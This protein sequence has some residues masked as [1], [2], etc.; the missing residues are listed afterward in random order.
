MRYELE[1]C[2]RD[3]EEWGEAAFA[4]EEFTEKVGGT[5]CRKRA[6]P[7]PVFRGEDP[8]LAVFV[9][10]VTTLCKHTGE[11]DQV[12]ISA[13]R[14]RKSAKHAPPAAAPADAVIRFSLSSNTCYD[15]A[16][17]G[18][19]LV[20]FANQEKGTVAPAGPRFDLHC[21]MLK[22]RPG[23]LVLR[24][25]RATRIDTLLCERERRVDGVGAALQLPEGVCNWLPA[26][27]G[28]RPPAPLAA[29]APEP[30]EE[31]APRKRLCRAWARAEVEDEACRPAP[32]RFMSAPSASSSA[33]RPGPTDALAA[34]TGV[35]AP[36]SLARDATDSVEPGNAVPLLAGPMMP[37]SYLSRGHVASPPAARRGVRVFHRHTVL[38]EAPAVRAHPML[39]S[40]AARPNVMALPCD[41]GA[42]GP[43]PTSVVGLHRRPEEEEE[44]SA[45][46]LPLTLLKAPSMDAMLAHEDDGAQRRPSPAAQFRQCVPAPAPVDVGALPGPGLVDPDLPAVDD[47]DGFAPATVGAFAAPFPWEGIFR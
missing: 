25:N 28:P 41:G 1:R 31:E 16:R 9:P 46:P 2:L 29:V 42:P 14:R 4:Y 21:Y 23:C 30:R 12:C 33:S 17:S 13:A 43:D 3:V 10:G 26:I 37:P 35:P 44:E 5:V 22:A 8:V 36:A 45:G 39:A 27:V 32:R 6:P 11:E 7:D 20:R 19:L 15:D 24:V 47:L 40:G 34:F 38:A 18:D